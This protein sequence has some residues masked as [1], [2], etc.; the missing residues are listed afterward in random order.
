[1][2]EDGGEQPFRV[3]ARAGE[4]IGMA[5]AGRFDLDQHLAGLRA[6]EL[7]GFDHQGFA[8]LV[9]HS[10]A[11]IHSLLSGSGLAQPHTERPREALMVAR[12]GAQVE[13]AAAAGVG[14]STW[15]KK[16]RPLAVW[17]S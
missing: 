9:G 3:G 17:F 15:A 5:Q 11:Y 4:F 6:G 10:G 12:V 14:T 13:A 2:A 7:D 16:R 8:G 1:M